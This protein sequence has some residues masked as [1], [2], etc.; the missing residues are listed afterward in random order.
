VSDAISS[1]LSQIRSL[2][3]QAAMRPASESETPVVGGGFSDSLRNAI[4]KV[5]TDQ[6]QAQGLARSFELGDPKT[7]LTQV[8]LAQQSAQLSFRATVEMRNRLVQ[9]YQDVMNMPL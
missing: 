3:A 5:N 7:S 8:M 9:A 2:H 1:I 4:S 6:Q